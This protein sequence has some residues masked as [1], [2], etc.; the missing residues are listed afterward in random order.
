MNG[1]IDDIYFEWLY[2]QVADVSER[3][4]HFTC[5]SLLKE[6]YTHPFEWFVPNDDNRA[7]D[8]KF[9]REEFLSDLN[10]SHD[11]EAW[12]DLKCSFLEMFIALARRASF[13]SYGEPYEWFWKFLENLELSQIVDSKFNRSSR[14]RI[15]RILETVNSRSYLPNGSG[16]IFPLVHPERDQREVEIWYQLAAYL[17]EG[18]Y[19]E[20][21]PRL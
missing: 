16:G 7:E 19:I 5:W 12:L 11:D 10:I 15:E 9:L 3:N 2:S 17:L 18:E 14:S 6:L 1:T 13:N 4:K 8:G 21:G 20:N